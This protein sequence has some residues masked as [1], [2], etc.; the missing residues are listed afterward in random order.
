MGSVWQHGK[1][2]QNIGRL[3][4]WD[5]PWNR[6][7]ALQPGR[8][9]TDRPASPSSA[10]SVAMLVGL[11]LQSSKLARL[12]CPW[13]KRPCPTT[14]LLLAQIESFLIIVITRHCLHF[15]ILNVC[16]IFKLMFQNY[17]LLFSVHQVSYWLATFS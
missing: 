3:A 11:Q 12:W 13:A 6:G 8:W 9:T 14:T 2:K 16:S 17:L 5:W 1:R 4:V 15:L 7:K 10:I